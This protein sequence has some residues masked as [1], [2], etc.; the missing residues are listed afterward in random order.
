SQ[1]GG[2]LWLSPAFDRNMLVKHNLLDSFR[3]SGLVLVG[4]VGGLTRGFYNCLAG[5]RVG[6]VL[7]TCQETLIINV[8]VK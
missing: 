5:S 8:S 2:L 1:R 3:V 7:P 6:N 4:F